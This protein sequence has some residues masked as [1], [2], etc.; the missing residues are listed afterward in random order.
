M[1]MKR[2]IAVFDFDGTLTTRDSFL[3]FIKWACGPVSYYVGFLRFTPQLLLMFM[4]LYPNWKAKERI[5]AHFFK[6]WQYSWFQALGEDFATELDTM[7]NE[8]VIGRLKEHIDHGDTVYVISAS[9]PEWVEPW[10]R[11]LGV[12]AVLATEIEVN[13]QGRITG[14]FKTKNCFGQEKVDRLL[15]VEPER[16]TYVLHAYGDSRGDLELLAFADE[17]THVKKK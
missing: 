17:A 4:H 7:R 10:C 9:L 2:N 11:Q 6:G 16:E 8:P 1:S 15:K 3:A 13:D 14:R 5:F 12:N